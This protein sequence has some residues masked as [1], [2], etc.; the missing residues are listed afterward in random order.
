[1]STTSVSLVGVGETST[2]TWAGQHERSPRP[3]TCILLAPLP[4]P[5]LTIPLPPFPPF[6][7][8]RVCI[9]YIFASL[10]VRSVRCF[11]WLAH[12]YKNW[13]QI[14]L[15]EWS[16]SNITTLERTMPSRYHWCAKIKAN[17]GVFYIN[18]ERSQVNNMPF[19]YRLSGKDAT[20]KKCFKFRMVRCLDINEEWL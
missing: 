5:C 19:S 1:V 16:R 3:L 6:Y 9:C 4:P 18:V 11:A 14:W 7:F 10:L 17:I 13:C 20:K 2:S 12:G 8:I 15:R